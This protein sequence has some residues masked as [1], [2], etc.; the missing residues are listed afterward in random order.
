MSHSIA[1]RVLET[2]FR[3]FFDTLLTSS[4]SHTHSSP[5][6]LPIEKIAITLTI[7]EKGTYSFYGIPDYTVLQSFDW[8]SLPEIIEQVLEPFPETR[9][10]LEVLLRV[11]STGITGKQV[12]DMEES[13]KKESAWNRFKSEGGDR[14][15]V[16][17]LPIL[18]KDEDSE[19]V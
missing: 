16:V 17:F 6:R 19:G 18:E 9:D 15:K 12:T 10:N 1:S 7:D 3:S 4:G 13:L 11:R 5:R 14:L 2:F 8:C